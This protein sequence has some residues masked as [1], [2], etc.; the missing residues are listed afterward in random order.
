MNTIQATQKTKK[1]IRQ[2]KRDL[3]LHSDDKVLQ[4]L[5]SNYKDTPKESIK[6]QPSIR[7]QVLN[8]MKNGDTKYLVDIVT[9]I[10]DS[11]NC[12][13]DALRNFIKSIFESA[14]NIMKVGDSE[15]RLGNV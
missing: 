6:H 10:A 12:D 11:T 15:Y 8:L 1:R 13:Y 9:E 4:L 3:D 2:L 5:L 14:P 7:S